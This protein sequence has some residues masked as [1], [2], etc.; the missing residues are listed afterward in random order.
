M[1]NSKSDYV[2]ID[3]DNIIDYVVMGKGNRD[4]VML[5][6]LSDGLQTV[7]SK[8][9]FLSMYYRKLA[10]QYR[11]YIFSR[12]RDLPKGCTTRDMADNVVIAFDKL[13]I[14]KPHLMGISMG[15]M[16]AQYIGINHPQKVD[17]VILAITLP[18]AD[19]QTTSLL[20]SWID[21]AKDKRDFELVKDTMEKTYTEKTLKKYRLIY[22]ILRL[23]S[24]IKDHNRFII[25]AEACINHNA[26]NELGNLDKPVLV[27]GGDE[28]RI[29]GNDSSRLI[30]QRLPNSK[31]YVYNGYGHGV[32]EECKKDFEER[33]V[34][35]L[36][37]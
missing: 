31:L 20:K 2:E 28:D 19:E 5:P 10:K 37:G 34:D 8:H 18:K 7:K 6:G 32:Y 13:G 33:M 29:A 24:R 17:K 1:F 26:Y 12:R 9:L 23:F 14:K 30:H 3:K 36:S 35:F 11:I 25:Q 15:G 21:M 22:P 4:L 27:I 16:I